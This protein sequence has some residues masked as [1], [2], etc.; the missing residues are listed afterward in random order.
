M[1]IKLKGQNVPK[2]FLPLSFERVAK[3]WGQQASK[4]AETTGLGLHLKGKTMAALDML[5]LSKEF[6]EVCPH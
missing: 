4:A 1:A 3:W 6:Q 5:N 2:C